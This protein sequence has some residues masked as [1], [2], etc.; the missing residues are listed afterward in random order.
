MIKKIL[1]IQPPTTTPLNN[2]S[3]RAMPP[4]GLA[5]I[6]AVLEK[7]G[8][9]VAILDSGVEGYD[10][11]IIKGRYVT[12]GLP[13]EEIKERIKKFNP[14]M[15]GVSC[16]FSPQINNVHK[17]CTAAKQVNKEIIT[18]VGG[19]HPTIQPKETLGNKNIDFVIMGEGEHRTLKLIQQINN[20]ENLK[21]IDGLAYRNNGRIIIQERTNYI[22]NLDELPFP[23]RHLLD[24]EK[25]FKINM[26]F[27]P[28][29]KGERVLQILTSRGCPMWC[30]FCASCNFWGLKY[31]MRS[32]ENVLAEIKHLK[33]KYGIGEMQ[34]A[35]DN[36]TLNKERAVKIFNGLK[37]L[38]LPWSTPAGLYIN[39]LD[40][41]TIK[42]MKD[43]GCYQIS[44][45]V[46]SGDPYVQKNIIGKQVDIQKAKKLIKYSQKIGIS[47]HVFYVIGLP[48]ETK[49]QM[50]TTFKASRYLDADSVSYYIATPIPGSK[51]YDMC[52]EAGCFREGVYDDLDLKSAEANLSEVDSKELEFWISNE[53]A[54][55]NRIYLIKHP[56]KF[57]KKYSGFI[58]SKKDSNSSALRN[59]ISVIYN[60][61]KSN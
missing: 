56:I 61:K 55:Y 36:L 41:E 54:K 12:Y 29:P 50:E 51:L 4:I 9:E 44:I 34:F 7:N 27:N 40:E 13:Y 18:F 2:K 49:K 25:Y 59:F 48:K 30:V 52:L 42:L 14:D 39:S 43:S 6:A 23:A 32:A 46:E 45:A 47:V 5:Y 8:F 20:K 26:P 60:F 19:L 17:T 58:I 28:F 10:W 31:R 3:K 22:G 35:D 57:F 1:L 24:M 15:V 21:D 16:A 37:E 33:E 11:E 38:N 53:T